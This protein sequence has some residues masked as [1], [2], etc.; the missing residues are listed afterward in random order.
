M[1]T[2]IVTGA[3]GGIGRSVVERFKADG[4]QV[5]QIDYNN[6]DD[7]P[8]LVQMDLRGSDIETKFD[9]LLASYPQAA[10]LV[11]CAGW[12]V[13]QD[14]FDVDLAGYDSNFNVNVRAV[15]L[16]SRAFARHLKNHALPGA[17]VNVSSVSGR[18]GSAIID[19]AASKSAVENLTKS[20]AKALAGSMIRVNAVAPGIVDTP[21]GRRIPAHVLEERIKTIPL[22]RI[23]TPEDIANVIA[24][25]AS[26]QAAYVNGQTLAVCGGMS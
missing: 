4:Y 15:F 17:I 6:P 11:N 23:A 1:Q 9:A 25:L 22:R 14:L 3:M 8:D 13:P 24:F 5:V 21:M 19:Y 10:V 26:D 2:A 12:Y 7:L 20:L 18:M 16:A